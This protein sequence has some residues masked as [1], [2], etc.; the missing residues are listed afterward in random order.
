MASMWGKADPSP[1]G[2][3]WTR[4]DEARMAAAVGLRLL[5]RER[6]EGRRGGA[7][8]RAALRAWTSSP[9]ALPPPVMRSTEEGEEQQQQQQ[10]LGRECGLLWRWWQTPTRVE[11]VVNLFEVRRELRRREK[12]LPCSPPS[13][14]SSPSSSPSPPRRRKGRGQQQHQRVEVSIGPRRLSVSLPASSGGGGGEDGGGW[15]KIDLLSGALFKRVAV[16]G[17]TWHYCDGLLFVSLLKLSRRGCYL[18]GDTAA[19][20][21]WRSVFEEEAEARKEEEEEEKEE[22]EREKAEEEREVEARPTATAAALASSSPSPFLK[23]PEPLPASAPLCY[24]ALP[25]DPDDEGRLGAAE[26]VAT[27]KKK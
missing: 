21:W 11:V 4:E 7:A 25:R 22:E 1:A 24:Y 5:E 27:R 12:L 9:D 16:D 10:L 3:R 15:E 8:G 18:D 20:T 26:R 23:L 19:E 6:E 14:S 17:S 2:P 13:S